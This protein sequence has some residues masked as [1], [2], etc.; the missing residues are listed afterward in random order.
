MNIATM[1]ITYRDDRFIKTCIDQLKGF[2]SQHVFLVSEKPWHGEEEPVG[3][4]VKSIEKHGAIPI[5]GE[6][7]SEAEQRN[8]GMNVLG[9]FD[10]I[11]IIDTDERYT[12]DSLHK[13]YAF[14]S[15]ANKPAYGIGRLLTYWK[16]TTTV[17]D[18]EET[19]GLIVACMPHVRFTDK[20]CIDSEWDF[21][22]QDIVMHHLSYVRTNE[23]MKRK[24]STFE[25]QHEIVPNWYE[26]KWL[27]GT[28]NLHP[29]N[30]ES[31]KGLKKIEEV[32]RV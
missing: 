13:L 12:V 32:V 9:S 15:T 22:P 7:E 20:R 30:P 16:N 8:V 2:V 10:W 23:E 18:P 31:F 5:L 17:V 4:I 28:E 1:T 29:V 14:L 19:G 25:H 27:S 24:I 21:L 3:D 11:L 6:W 26:E